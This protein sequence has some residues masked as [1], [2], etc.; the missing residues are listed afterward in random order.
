MLTYKAESGGIKTVGDN[1]PHVEA[2]KCYL[3]I[4]IIIGNVYLGL[5]FM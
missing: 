3:K 1:I 5:R 4:N 2:L